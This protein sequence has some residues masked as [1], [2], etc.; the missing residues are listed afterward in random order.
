MCAY[1]V[2]T[3]SR[4]ILVEHLLSNVQLELPPSFTD[5]AMKVEFVGGTSQPFIPTPCKMTE[6]S[7]ALCG[8]LGTAASVIS[9]A[10]YD[11]D[12]QDVTVNTDTASLLLMSFKLPSINGNPTWENPIIQEE[13][14]EGDL[15]DMAKP[16]H[17]QCTNL[18]KTK[19]GRFFH[20][21]G[22][23]N[24]IHT[25]NMLGVPEQD[26]S[27]ETANAIYSEKVAQWD[28]AT[29]ERVAND[30]YKQSGVVCYTPDEFFASEQ[31]KPLYTFKPIQCPRKAW[32]A[33]KD[34]KRPLDGVRVI[35]YSRVVAGPTISKLLALLGAEVIKVTSSRL[36]DITPTWVDLSTGK[37]DCDVDLTTSTGQAAFKRIL[38]S[39]DVLIDG[40]RPGVL[41]RFGFS[42][43]SMRALN[44]S[45]IYLRENCYGWKG[46]LSHRSGWQQISDCLAGISW[47]QG[48]FLGLDEPVVPLLPNSDYQM[49]IAGAVAILHA[50]LRRATEDFTFDIDISLTQYNI[51]YYRL[52]QYSEEQAVQIL[53]R[54]PGFHVR[55]YDEMASLLSKT[56]ATVRLCRPELFK[57]PDNFECISGIEWGIE[58][59][60]R[61]LASPIRLSESTLKYNMPSGRRGRSTLEWNETY[62]SLK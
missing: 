2:Q 1:S 30:Q 47:L 29:I 31:A 42:S 43:T 7:S 59:D 4:R 33:S 35:D 22:S 57:N 58:E 53:E 24:A 19:D 45:L 36:P 10:R 14:A 6:S 54:N 9:R 27:S 46:P 52:G 55:H 40:Y 13:L 17:R 41:E 11:I 20:L 28:S 51:W 56:E 21:H 34:S 62:S 18:Y 39:A 25:M 16:I 38:S 32:P 15:Y 49:G 44:P 50:L 37:K 26:V 48:K 23:M 61:I 60:I 3:E 8:L 5:A 12:Y